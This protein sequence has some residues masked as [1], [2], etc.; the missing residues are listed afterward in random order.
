MVDASTFQ[1]YDELKSE[2]SL[3]VGVDER[4]TKVS[5]ELAQAKIDLRK[6][7]EANE[8]NEKDLKEQKDRIELVKDHWFYGTTA[9]QPQLW[10]RGGVEGKKKRA[11]AKLDKCELES[12]RLMEEKRVLEE[13]TVPG[14]EADKKKLG[15]LTA[16][17][18]TLEFEIAGL[19]DQIV[20]SR[21]SSTLSAMQAQIQGAQTQAAQDEQAAAVLSQMVERC[22]SAKHHY[23]NATKAVRDAQWENDRASQGTQRVHQHGGVPNHNPNPYNPQPFGGGNSRGPGSGGVSV[24]FN[25]AAGAF[26]NALLDGEAARQAAEQQRRHQMQ[27]DKRYIAWPTLTLKPTSSPP[28]P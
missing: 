17:K 24:D 19:R 11:E 13:Q 2:A 7:T 27:R 8:A 12:P 3:M 10:F 22:K 20:A 9:L 4:L 21:P 14:L 6:A 26:G 28:S 15:G 25:S 1:R 5:T 18:Q 23:G 16:R